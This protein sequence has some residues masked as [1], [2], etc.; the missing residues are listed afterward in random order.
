VLLVCN[1]PDAVAQV[2]DNWKP[3]HDPLR[4][5][6]LLKLSPLPGWRLDA[7]HYAAGK[8]AIDRILA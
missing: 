1:A 6:R 8:S 3:A 5:A 4:A 7:A 2:L